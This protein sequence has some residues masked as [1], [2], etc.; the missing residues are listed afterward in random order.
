[1]H[2]CP[3]YYEDPIR[4][5]VFAFTGDADG[6]NEPPVGKDTGRFP[7]RPPSLSDIG[8]SSRY[9]LGLCL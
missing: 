2:R 7:I 5:F 3:A 9:C 8:W 1:M 4:L 6:S